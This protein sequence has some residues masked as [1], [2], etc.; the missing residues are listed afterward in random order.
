MFD[1]NSAGLNSSIIKQGHNDPSCNCHIVSTALANCPRYN[2]E[3]NQYR[4]TNLV[5]NEGLVPASRPRSM[6]LVCADRRLQFLACC[7]RVLLNDRIQV[8]QPNYS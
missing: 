1:Q 2:N 3:I 6:F 5:H 4:L 8:T 7:T